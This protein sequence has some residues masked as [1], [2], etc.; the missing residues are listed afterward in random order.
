MA[1]RQQTKIIDA[2]ICKLRVLRGARG[3]ANYIEPVGG[4]RYIVREPQDTAKAECL[5]SA[6]SLR[7]RAIPREEGRTTG[8]RIG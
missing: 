2:L 6:L 7:W 3:G 4:H 8:Q 5:P 1:T